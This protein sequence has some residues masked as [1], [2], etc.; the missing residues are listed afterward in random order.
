L[1]DKYD[2]TIDKAADSEVNKEIPGG[3]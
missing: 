2:S 1:G 3:K